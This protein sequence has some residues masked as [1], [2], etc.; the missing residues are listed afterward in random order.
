MH[1]SWA[2]F[3]DRSSARPSPPSLGEAMASKP[4]ISFS[5]ELLNYGAK[6]CQLQGAKHRPLGCHL[7]D[8][9]QATKH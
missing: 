8:P 6:E 3:W 5:T 4:L 7:L 1:T 9:G 2:K